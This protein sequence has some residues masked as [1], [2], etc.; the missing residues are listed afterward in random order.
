MRDRALQL[1]AGREQPLDDHVVQVPGDPFP[2]PEDREQ[3]SFLLRPDTLQGERGVPGEGRQLYR[4]LLQELPAGGPGHDQ[5]AVQS[6]RTRQRDGHRRAVR[7][8]AGPVDGRAKIGH[9]SELLP[10]E[11]GGRRGIHGHE[12][13]DECAAGRVGAVSDLDRV[14][15]VVLVVQHHQD[16]FGVGDLTGPAGDELQRLGALDRAQQNTGDL[17]GRGEP[18]LPALDELVQPGVV[19]GDTGCGGQGHHDLLVVVTELGGVLFLGQVQIAEDLVAGTNRD[20]EEAVHRWVVRWEPV[21]VGMLVDVRQPDRAWLGDQQTQH[22]AAVWQIPDPRVGGRVDAVSDE[23]GQIGA[24]GA[25]HAE[26]TVPGVGQGARGFDDTLQGAAQAEVRAD[27]DDRVEER[28]QPFPA[29]H[30]LADSV[31][32]F[33]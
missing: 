21:R 11:V 30:H 3:L 19:D 26:R 28:P 18:A 31:E 4:V 27:A 32:H 7:H 6:P 1:H 9:V 25:D 20:T 24:V 2:V 22:T 8:R 10:S 15:G 16:E 12:L 33:L 23:V 14:L 13:A 29:G 5:H 17:S